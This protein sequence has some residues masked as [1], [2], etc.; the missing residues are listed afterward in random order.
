MK[1]Y[2]T[3]AKTTDAI[4]PFKQKIKSRQRDLARDSHQLQ[5]TTF[6]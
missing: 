6:I 1:K 4:L 3:F 5:L 2:I